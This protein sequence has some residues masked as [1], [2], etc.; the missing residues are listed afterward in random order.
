MLRGPSEGE[1]WATV[2]VPS[3]PDPP[4]LVL[5]GGVAPLRSADA[6]RGRGWQRGGRVGGDA[7]RRVPGPRSGGRGPG[8]VQ[9]LCA[10]AAASHGPRVRA[11]D[12]A[13]TAPLAWPRPCLCRC[14][15]WPAPSL[16]LSPSPAPSPET[17]AFIERLEMEQAQKAKNPQEQ[18]SFFAKYVSRVPPVAPF[19]MS[20]PPALSAPCPAHPPGLLPVGRPALLWGL[21]AC[22]HGPRAEPRPARAEQLR[23][24]AHVTPQHLSRASSLSDQPA[25]SWRCWEP[26]R[27][28]WRQTR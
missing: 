25:Q 14:S 1:A 18:K 16:T 12:R 24:A 20:P 22:P 23:A 15:G 2:P 10:A 17:A 8:A 9:H 26:G 28:G 7:P 4:P 3:S 11:Q 21:R 27:P 19:L 13:H 6:A 5:P